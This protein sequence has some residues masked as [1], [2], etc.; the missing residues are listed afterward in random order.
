MEQNDQGI[1]NTQNSSGHGN[2]LVKKLG[3]ILSVFVFL[4]PVFFVPVA[5]IGLYVAKITL[6]ATGLVAI[7]AIF[8]SSVLS[9]GAIEMPKVKYLIP[10]G[11]FA[12]IA[13]LSSVF[14]GS[15]ASSVAGSVFDLGTSG[16]IVMLV[17][18]MFMTVLAV[19]SVGVVGKIVTAFI[20]STVAMSVYTLFAAFGA[21]LIPTSIASK[22]PIFLSGGAIDTA[23]IF[24]AA[25]IL[26][27]CAVN[28]SEVSKKMQYIMYALIAFALIFI[29]AVKFTPV[30]IILGIISLVFF[31]Y[32]LSWSV[33]RPTSPEDALQGSQ[34]RKISLSSLAVLIAS[35]IL[36]LGGTGISGFFSKTLRIQTTE[37]RPNFQS[38]MDL[39]L[40]SW[41]QNIALGVGPNRFSEFWALHK[42]VEINQTQ[43]WNAEFY[44]GSGFI[45]TMA[46]TTGLLGLLSLLAFIV[47]YLLT[48]V[49]A[50]FA[51]ANAGRSRYLS[52][53][54]FLVSLYFWIML[55][56]YTPSI[57]IMALTFIFTGLFTATLVPQG[58]IGSWKINIF[59]NPKTNFLSVLSIVILLIMSVAGGYFVW[60]RSAAAVVFEKSVLIYQQNAN[61]AEAR[62]S[63]AKS[64]GMVQ[65][66]VYW[67]GLT[68]ISLNDF[69]RV[70]GGVTNQNQMTDAIRTEAQGLIADSVESAKRAVALDGGNFQNW[71]ALARV[72]EVLG[73]NG[74]EGSLENARSTYVEAALRS[75]NNPSVPLALARLDALAG[76]TEEAKANIV[77]ALELKN[78]YTDA[79]FTLAQLQVAQNDIASAIKSVEAAVVVEPNN[80]GLYFQL[81][82]LK[83]NQKDYAGAASALESAVKLVPSYANAKYFLGMAY[84]KIGRKD[85]S[86]KQF[87]EIK[88]TNPDNTEVALIVE[89][90]KAGK[91]LFADAKPPVDKTPEKRSELPI[92]EGN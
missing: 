8:L 46:I 63:I 78:N 70:L 12:L 41:K 33:G 2:V 52:T 55:F 13:I 17:F 4:L 76:R 64:L 62:T 19:K 90:M 82:M 80:T 37:I 10:I 9:T 71:Y 28:M 59:S 40:S 43:F 18:L 73:S 54:S 56:L 45:P 7:F 57:V 53:A 92:K 44:S 51:Q 77:K 86:L 66:D 61:V 47:M 87:E 67:R 6:L 36:L 42:P 14:S 21:S 69:G 79:Y 22:L 85:D 24:G 72:Y 74:V 32:I 48:G 1:Q 39:T 65:S 91:E 27:L 83:Y 20:Y 49:K 5:G 16:S 50:I 38:T 25:V 88:A 68:E 3:L 75:P 81:G 58:I 29:A 11:A 89:N 60:E 30:V 26:A 15:I 34:D 31:V 35:V 23:I 84:Y